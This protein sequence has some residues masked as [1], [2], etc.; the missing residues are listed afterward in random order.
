MSDLCHEFYVY[1]DHKPL[2][3]LRTFKDIIQKRYRWILFLEDIGTKI[4]YLPGEENLVADFLSRNPK[5]EKKL[6]VIGC[7]LIELQALNYPA[8][9]IMAAQLNDPIL[10]KV[11]EYLQN[12]ANDCPK[13]FCRYKNVLVLD[14]LL[15]YSHH[16]KYI[17]VAPEDFR[18]EILWLCHNQFCAGHLGLFKTHQRVLELFW[19]PNLYRD[20][21][22]FISR[23]D[24]CAGIKPQNKNPARMGIRQFP[25]RPMDLVS[26]DYMVDL[27]VTA[28]GNRHLLAINDHFSKFMQLY[29][30]RDRRANTAARCVLDFFL[31]FGIALKLYS[32]CDPAFESKLFQELMRLLGVKKLRT[33][34]YNAKA[35]GLT[36]KSNEF[37]K[38]YLTAYC[39]SHRTDWDL[40]NREACYAHNSSVHTST[41]FT[42]ARL[43]F[44]REYR[45]PMNILYGMNELSR[46]LSF[47]E[48]EKEF[49]EIYEIARENI[50]TRQ[51]KMATYYDRK[52]RD[53][54]LTV[55]QRVLVRDP[56]V[57]SNTLKYKWVSPGKVVTSK[58]PVYEVEFLDG[59]RKWLTRDRLK[60]V[61]SSSQVTDEKSQKATAEE[62]LEEV[63]SDDDLT[64]EDSS[65]STENEE[66]EIHQ[67]G[68]QGRNI[69]LRPNPKVPNRYGHYVTHAM[70]L[71][72]NILFF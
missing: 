8:E 7:S 4:L 64:D 53:H 1:T 21:N 34:G 26:I 15:K 12:N 14:G 38:N 65:S 39:N 24:V 52:V 31:K 33:T 48:Y 23:C 6:D 25:T 71:V 16:G 32:D 59:S 42:A 36:E 22:N 50:S 41:K 46:S 61:L 55:D 2:I 54:E 60:L 47:S 49:Q 43:M 45:M 66:E 63:L 37:S 58:H 10:S 69:R 17:L 40:W 18:E 35:N 5:V 29:P 51:N 28:R 11:I 68:A 20:V 30:V 3:Y 57:K 13:E 72:Q 27:P 9:E 44:G 70:S 67:G 19:W 62:N 56:R